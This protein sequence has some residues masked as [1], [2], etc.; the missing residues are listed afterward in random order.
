[1]PIM[2]ITTKSSTNVNAS[3]LARLHI[4]IAPR[5]QSQKRR[6]ASSK[7]VLAPDGRAEPIVASG[8]RVV[9]SSPREGTSARTGDGAARKRQSIM[10]RNLPE[11]RSSGSAKAGGKTGGGLS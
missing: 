10:K 6:K 9:A 1:M 11:L 5:R 8:R 7:A 3:R 4:Q 2:A